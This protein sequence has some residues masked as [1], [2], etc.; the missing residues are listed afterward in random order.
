MAVLL[1]THTIAD[2]IVQ[3]PSTPEPSPQPST[4]PVIEF[5]PERRAGLVSRRT[6]PSAEVVEHARRQAS[7][8]PASKRRPSNVTPASTV[9]RVVELS[10]T[11]LS[12][13]Q[14]ASKVG[15][16]PQTV[17]NI[18]KRQETAA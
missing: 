16:S 5:E 11:G 13:R 2:L 15:V 18:L 17:S 14:V 7:K 6:P 1:A 4:A 9:A 12:Y 10:T 3:R 8:R